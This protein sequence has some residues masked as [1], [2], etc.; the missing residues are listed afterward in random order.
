MRASWR[1]DVTVG[2]MAMLHGTHVGAGTLVGMKATLLSRSVV[3]PGSLI[4]AGAL[5]L[6]GQ[7]IPAK[8]LAAG[9][10]AKV[11]RELSDEQSHS[12]IPHAGRYVDLSKA[13][14]L[15]DA[16]VSLEDVYYD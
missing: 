3:G 4:A 14:A 15:S 12:F 13:Q 6:E 11:R 9:I 8:S 16:A 7:E 2:H 5:V 10:P 1:D